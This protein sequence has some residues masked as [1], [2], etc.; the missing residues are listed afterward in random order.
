MIRRRDLIKKPT[1][2]GWAAL[3]NSFHIADYAEAETYSDGRSHP[4][5]SK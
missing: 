5:V 3:W 4:K 2:T 1:I